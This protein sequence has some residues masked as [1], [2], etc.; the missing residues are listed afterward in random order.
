[1]IEVLCRDLLP[2]GYACMVA[3]LA[4]VRYGWCNSTLTSLNT[5]LFP[6]EEIIFQMSAIGISLLSKFALRIERIKFYRKINQSWSMQRS[7]RPSAQ[8]MAVSRLR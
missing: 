4:H 2:F 5:L 7:T 6:G 8:M 3:F 1:M